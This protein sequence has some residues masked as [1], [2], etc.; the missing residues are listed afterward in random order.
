MN[1]LIEAASF[2]PDSLIERLGWVLIH[3]LWQFALVA[4]IAVVL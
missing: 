3:S 2:L 1:R 4:L